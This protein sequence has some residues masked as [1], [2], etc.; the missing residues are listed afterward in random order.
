MKK[1]VTHVMEFEQ[2]EISILRIMTF[3]IYFLEELG[4]NFVSKIHKP[5]T[6]AIC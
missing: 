1:I 3:Y 6:I 4:P 2:I 5:K